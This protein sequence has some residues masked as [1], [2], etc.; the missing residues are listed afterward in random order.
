MKK[1]FALLFALVCILAL[2][3]CSSE[4]KSFD[5]TDVHKIVVYAADGE[6]VEITDTNI[7]QQI[8]DNINSI[9]FEKGKSN[10]DTNGLGI[11]VQWYDEN[12]NMLEVVSIM[13][14]K[15]ISYGDNFWSASD[16]TI[17]IALI[18]NLLQ[19]HELFENGSGDNMP[20]RGGNPN[21]YETQQGNEVENTQPAKTDTGMGEPVAGGATN[22]FEEK[23][24][25]ENESTQPAWT[26]N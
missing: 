5:I 6:N 8:T 9:Q 3:A 24:N 11:I 4:K 14:E 15:N 7:I 17:D 10:K 26:D 19:E 13:D 16:G 23:Q 25:N 1:L 21:A 18:N 2:N 22:S 12:G 20:V